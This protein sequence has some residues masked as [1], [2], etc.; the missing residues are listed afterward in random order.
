MITPSKLARIKNPHLREMLE[1]QRREIMLLKSLASENESFRKKRL[2]YNHIRHLWMMFLSA[3]HNI[4][5]L[6]LDET[7]PQHLQRVSQFVEWVT[8]PLAD[9]PCPY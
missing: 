9:Q 2:S 6:R 5:G 3:K 1:R 7:N 4:R 8:I